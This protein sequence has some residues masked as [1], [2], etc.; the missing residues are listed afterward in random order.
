[1]PITQ[2]RLH[3][4]LLAGQAYRDA[5]RKIKKDTALLFNKLLDNKLT[6]AEILY[7]VQDV[8][9]QAAPDE[10]LS[11]LISLELGAISPAGMRKNEAQQQAQARYRQRR[12]AQ[13]QLSPE[14]FARWEKETQITR[15]RLTRK[16]VRD[17]WG[18]VPLNNA[19]K[20]AAL[21][22][23]EQNLSLEE[24]IDAFTFISKVNKVDSDE[25]DIK[26]WKAA[27]Q[28]TTS[29]A[30]IV[31]ELADKVAICQKHWNNFRGVPNPLP[32]STNPGALS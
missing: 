29:E 28:I 17:V 20:L 7:L 30:E 2:Q 6:G 8:I 3:K 5:Y 27:W 26:Q 32:P 4:L 25:P 13:L 9:N 10:A 31:P 22:P 12:A 18:P 15:E 21:R 19:M 11:D 1:M 23:A 16:K 24:E 14:E